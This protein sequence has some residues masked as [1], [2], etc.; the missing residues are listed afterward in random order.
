MLLREETTHHKRYATSKAA[1]NE[2]LVRYYFRLMKEKGEEAFALSKGY[3]YN[4]CGAVFDISGVEAGRIIRWMIAEKAYK[5]FLSDDEC[6]EYL[7]ILVRLNKKG[8]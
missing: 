3:L 2:K 7:E 8:V 1:R 4:Q 5:K 6:N